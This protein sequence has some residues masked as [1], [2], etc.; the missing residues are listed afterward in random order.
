MTRRQRRILQVALV[1]LGLVALGVAA[2]G[3]RHPDL[4]LHYSN[5]LLCS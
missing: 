3:Y 2:G 4:L 1:V 5:L